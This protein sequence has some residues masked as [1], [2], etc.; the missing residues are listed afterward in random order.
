MVLRAAK[1]LMKASSGE[2][3]LRAYRR[4]YYALICIDTVHIL[5]TYKVPDTCCSAFQVSVFSIVI[6]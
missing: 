2:I 1:L 5:G 3:R 4:T 6:H